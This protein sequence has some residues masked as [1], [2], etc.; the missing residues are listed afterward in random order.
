VVETDTKTKS[1]ESANAAGAR[2]QKQFAK[3]S[4]IRSNAKCRGL[5][6]SHG[7]SGYALEILRDIEWLA[8]FRKGIFF[9]KPSWAA[10]K[11]GCRSHWAR[12]IFQWLETN[13]LIE[14][15]TPLNNRPAYIS[16]T[17]KGWANGWA[18]D[19]GIECA[20]RA[21]DPDPKPSESVAKPSESVAK[22]SESVANLQSLKVG[23]QKP[24]VNT[25]KQ[26]AFHA[27]SYSPNASLNATLNAPTN[28]STDAQES[29]AARAG[30]SAGDLEKIWRR[31]SESNLPWDRPEKNALAALNGQASRDEILEAWEAYLEESR[32][33]LNRP[34]LHFAKHAEEF[35]DE[36]R[37]QNLNEMR[38]R[39]YS[40]LFGSSHP[41]CDPQDFRRIE[42]LRNG[43]R[44]GCG[45]YEV[46]HKEIAELWAS[47]GFCS[48]PQAVMK[49]PSRILVVETKS[50]D[51]IEAKYISEF[52]LA[53]LIEVV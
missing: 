15:T 25:N 5:W 23:L 1:S 43:Q 53:G 22:P 21:P 3:V 37:K 26:Q 30:V 10:K 7:I 16:Q 8:R 29:R 11:V 34:F 32:P 18:K 28:A 46:V 48:N 42:R 44:I 12:A 36:V 52:E 31:K 17:H 24:S 41:D 33:G 51:W 47:K 38:E 40:N 39:L 20:L 27:G 4:R 45:H 49:H 2:I 13:G 14:P 50:F 6:R 35:L 9:C 19:H